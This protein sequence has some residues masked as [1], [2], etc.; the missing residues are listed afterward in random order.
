MGDHVFISY[1]HKD[2]AFVGEMK[3]SLESA[4]VTVKVDTEFLSGG[5][6][7]MESI[8][9]NIR[10]AAALILVMSPESSASNYV[11]Y[12]WAFAFGSDIPVIPIMLRTTDVHPRLSGYQYIT[13]G[14]SYEQLA[15]DILKA[16]NEERN[17]RAAAARQ[18]EL[19]STS[20][21]MAQMRLG[22]QYYH[23]NDI[24]HALQTY[25]QALRSARDEVRADV[26][27]QTAYVL[28]KDGR[29][30]RADELIGEAL[31]R[32]PRYADALATRGLIYSAQARDAQ[33]DA[34]LRT[35]LSNARDSLKDAL[36]IEDRLRDLDGESWWAT[37]G[38]VYRRSGD[39][40]AAIRAYES[41]LKVNDSSYPLS[42]LARLYVQDKQVD[43]AKAT[44]RTVERL[45]QKRVSDNFRDYWAYND[46]IEA[47]TAL[48]KHDEADAHLTDF[49]AL[50]TPTMASRL[51]GSLLETL[52]ALAAAAAGDEAAQIKPLVERVQAEIAG[53]PG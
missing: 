30:E 20:E 37:L 22:Q 4:G 24:P 52:N 29:L 12:E 32:R 53:L 48:G 35:L 42:N 34:A 36:G 14:Y 39:Y 7:W 3:K 50:L 45:A 46:M 25:E 23:D 8:D 31:T 5:T 17:Q 49:L 21:T 11:T 19:V 44:Y 43:K 41:A 10:S 28:C 51:L 15:K 2:S 6:M 38:G 47:E 9:S 13:F 1:S 26:C 18:R 16:L 33:D 40:S 27:T